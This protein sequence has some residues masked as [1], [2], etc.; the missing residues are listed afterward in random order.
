M[1]PEQFFPSLCRIENDELECDIALWVH[2]VLGDA[3]LSARL[4]NIVKE[5]Q[6]DLAVVKLQVFNL[7]FNRYLN[8]QEV[9]DFDLDI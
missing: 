3:V 5:Y 4:F 1:T 2:Y 6:D 8:F 9:L 7:C